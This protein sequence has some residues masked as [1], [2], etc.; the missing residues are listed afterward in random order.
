MPSPHRPTSANDPWRARRDILSVANRRR[1]LALPR[2]VRRRYRGEW[3]RNQRHR[4]YPGVE[5]VAA[6]GFAVRTS[7]PLTF[8]RIGMC[9][10]CFTDIQ[11]FRRHI[12]AAERPSGMTSHDV[13]DGRIIETVAPVMQNYAVRLYWSIGEACPSDPGLIFLSGDEQPLAVGEADKIWFNLKDKLQPRPRGYLVYYRPSGKIVHE[14][15]V[16]SPE[17]ADQ[18]P[19]R[20]RKP[21]G[22]SWLRVWSR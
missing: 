16:E 18:A 4:L 2:L 21:G 5:R 17:F 8:V 1:G 19:A 22:L 6:N 14:R 13:I 12:G 7:L 9:V 11:V 3:V 15:V 20:R 10:V